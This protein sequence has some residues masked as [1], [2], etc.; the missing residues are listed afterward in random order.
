[1][2]AEPSM[3]F[4]TLLRRYREAAGL[5][6]EDLAERAGLTEKGIGAL[7]RGER[8]RPQ[9]HTLQQLATALQLSDQERAAFI[10]AVPQR[11]G[12]GPALE[13]APPGPLGRPRPSC[14]PL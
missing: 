12:G 10:A 13:V 3:P 8:K 2:S 6:Q 1:M 11:T 9:P 5:S 7:E 14:P 4:G